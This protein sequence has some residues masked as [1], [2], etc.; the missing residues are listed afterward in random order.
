MSFEN[1]GGFDRMWA[2]LAP[3]GRDAT[4]GGYRR[5]AWTR[6]DAVLREW[7]RGEATSRGLEVVA[8]RAGNLWAWTAH[9]DTA[10]PGLVVGSHLDS[11]PDGGAFDGPLGVVS[12]FAA[13]DL[14]D[15][16]TLRR[17]V[18]IAC[19]ADEEGARFGVACAGSRLITGVLDPDRARALTD[20]SGTNMAEALSAAGQD[21]NVLGR[22]D[23]A[24][25][26]VGTFLELHV[27]QGRALD[28]LDA[29][30]GVAESI[31]PHGRWRLDLRGRADH[32][33]TTRL[34]DRDDP[35]LALAAVVLEARSAAERRGALATV[36]KVRVEPNGVNAIPSAV[37][38]WLDARG[39]AE[40]AVRA[41]VADVSGAA[42][43]VPVEESWTPD[44]RFDPQLRDRLASLLGAPV[45][46]TGAGHDAG[47]LSAAGI[48]TAML[49]VR[50]PTGV[51]HSPAEHAEPADCLAGVAALARAIEALA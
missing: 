28:D 5:F 47:I 23:E 37:T 17:P 41:L 32:A 44:T 51:S 24:L 11:V 20:D 21:P 43:T 31:W 14:L 10:G 25:R 45:L 39:P 33:G 19:F 13:L 16:A 29:P 12:A 34:A 40:D 6:E 3:L 35:M 18:G 2:D 46:P 26:R 4:T 50:N 8:D 30:V 22:D 15:R 1:S 49:F 42:G 38:A 7:F 48:P 27:E 9:P 36:G